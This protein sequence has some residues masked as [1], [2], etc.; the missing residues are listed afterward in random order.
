MTKRATH[1]VT[2]SEDNSPRECS[3]RLQQLEEDWGKNEVLK[4]QY[5][6]FEDYETAEWLLNS[7]MWKYDQ[8]I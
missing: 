6:T 4:K 1:I 2:M 7:D 8:L 3:D 5:Q